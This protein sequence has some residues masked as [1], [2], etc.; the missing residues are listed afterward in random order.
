MAKFGI[1]DIMDIKSKTSGAD[2]ANDYKEIWLNPYEVKPSDSNFYAQEN[3]EEL[4]DSFLAVGQQQPT[5]LGKVDG[6]FWIV[7]GH[8]RNRAN[9]LNIERGHQEYQQVRYLYKDMTQPMLELSLLMGNAYNRELTAWEKT[10]QAKRLKEALMRAKKEDGLEIPGKLRDV[11]AGLMNESSSNIAKMESITHNAV[12]EIQDQFKNGN[13]GISAAYEAAKLSPE[14]QKAVAEKTAEG[15][16]ISVKEIAGK[17]T[18]KKDGGNK[19]GSKENTPDQSISEQSIPEQEIQE[20][21]IQERTIQEQAIQKEKQKEGFES[22]TVQQPQKEEK[23]VEKMSHTEKVFQHKKILREW[24]K[25]STV[26]TRATKRVADAIKKVSESNTAPQKNWKDIDWAV[27]LTK[28]IMHRADQV[29]EEDL[30][31]LHDIMSRCQ[32]KNEGK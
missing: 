18:A 28:A 5:V 32:K 25:Q 22:N 7:S 16:N 11:V 21:T 23:P 8:R 26:I 12:Q 31:L 6:Q 13:M 30:Y 1:N 29:S 19:G 17:R 15:K 14:E 27:F 10:Q 4:A 24:E 2:G 3:I 20:R 9:I